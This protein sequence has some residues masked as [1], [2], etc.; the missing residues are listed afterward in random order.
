LQK[1]PSTKL[2]K[3]ARNKPVRYTYEHLDW[4]ELANRLALEGRMDDLFRE[5][6]LAS[7]G[8]VEE[9]MRWLE[10]AAQ[11]YRRDIGFDPKDFEKRLLEQGLIVKDQGE[12]RL[13]K[14]GEQKLRSSSLESVFGKLRA[15]P[16]GEHTIPRSGQTGEHTGQLRPWQPG[17]ES[18]D[19]SYRDSMLNSLRAGRGQLDEGDLVINER[20][21]TTSAATV[22]LLD[23]SH[24]M[25]LY[26][27][28]RIT[29]AKRVALAL[30]ELQARRYPRDSFNVL[31]FGDDVREVDV[32]DLPYVTNGPY[33]TNTCEA[34]R[35]A[36]EILSKKKQPNKRVIM[37]TDGK[38]TALFVPPRGGRKGGLMINT[39]GLDPEIVTATLRQGA[40]YPRLKIEMTIFM[41]ASDPYLERFISRLVEVSRGRAFR[42]SLGDLGEQ[43]LKQIY[44]K[45]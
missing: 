26:G 20:E 41:V 31:L 21:A 2:T 44:G 1:L 5:L 40:R 38:P 45:R 10:Q 6:M 14:K 35:R 11:R 15:G 30:A 25:T 7:A 13:T 23:I 3:D 4:R 24:S 29:P 18:Y 17:D 37:I 36:A 34:L 27:E 28:D 8:D 33:H 43:V 16:H 32:A 9:A 39:V 22:L 12:R 19:L 42:A